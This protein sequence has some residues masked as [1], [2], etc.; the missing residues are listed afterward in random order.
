[1]IQNHKNKSF[2]TI[3][4]LI[5][6]ILTSIRIILALIAPV[7]LFYNQK[8]ALILLIIASITD[9]FDGFLARKLNA[10]SNLGRILD[11][12]ADKTLIISSFT[13]LSI[14]TPLLLSTSISCL[15][16][17][18]E[19]LLILGLYMLSDD[20]S[21]TIQPTFLGKI[22][23]A[24]TFFYI[25]AIVFHLS[26]IYYL[27]Y[28]LLILSY[29]TLYVYAKKAITSYYKPYSST[30]SIDKQKKICIVLSGGSTSTFAYSEAIRSFP[31]AHVMNLSD[32]NI[33]FYRKDISTQDDF[34]PC[35]ENILKYDLIIFATPVYWYST[36]AH[37]KIFMDR[38]ADLLYFHEY[39]DYKTQFATKKYA[40]IIQYSRNPGYTKQII[41]QTCE[42]MKATFISSWLIYKH[43][44]TTNQRKKFQR[45]CYNSL[46]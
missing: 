2:K 1:M 14:N 41:K 32:Y 19:L 37:L 17:L 28:P 15:F 8:I 44:T 21:I 43:N 34:I 13:C 25:C 6:N 5:P 45:K 18:R 36:T 26:Y 11:P 31:H 46:S 22:N 7:Y 20:S 29:Y 4:K 27:T 3:L 9:F 38:L 39:L 16:I 33:D 24:L 40:A 23:A 30:D 12:V 10:A 35:L 42:Y